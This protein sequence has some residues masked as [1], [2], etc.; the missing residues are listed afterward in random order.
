MIQ[1][2]TKTRQLPAYRRIQQ[3][4]QASIDD[5][6]LHPG[7]AVSSERDL[8]RLHGVSL[9]TARQALRQMEVEGVV[10]R[11]PGVGT[12]VAQP[13]I[14]FNKLVGF[15][16]QMA[17]RGFSAHSRLLCARL[18]K[19]E[20]DLNS[21][22]GLSVAESIVKIERLRLADA[23]PFAIEVC[24]LAGGAYAG[25]VDQPLD[26]RSLFSILEKE[27]GTEFA[28]ADE[29]VDATTA[30]PRTADLLKVPR[31]APILRIRQL[32]YS[33][34]GRAV[35]YSLALYRS[36]RYSLVTRRFR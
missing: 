31:G 20:Y 17:S 1:T 26:R 27:Y 13:R 16:E 4:V 6:T 25:I 10:E 33:T 15:T 7:D 3:S 28:Y 8:A 32:L 18:V 11:R 22:L 23:Q 5:G 9:M 30:D 2:K 19:G 21:R 35:V 36:D 24:Y 12:F 34:A 29:E 14:Q